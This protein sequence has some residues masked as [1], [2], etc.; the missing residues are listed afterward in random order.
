[1][2][3]EV[4]YDDLDYSNDCVYL[5]QGKP[6][7]GVGVQRTDNGSLV[8]EVPFSDGK[9][10]GVAREYFPS[11]KVK[12]ETPYFRGVAHGVEREWHENGRLKTENHNE[13]GILMEATKWSVD[14]VVEEHFVRDPKDEFAK[15][16]SQ[17]RE[18][19]GDSV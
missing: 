4:L 6:F 13:F 9:E 16:A 17:R 3:I 11:G 18:Q 10:H 14:G 8:C 12:S 15:V 2:T 7:S 1:M 19:Y 5:L